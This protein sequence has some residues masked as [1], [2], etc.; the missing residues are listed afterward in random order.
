MSLGDS[1][2]NPLAVMLRQLRVQSG[3]DDK[4]FKAS[5][6]PTVAMKDSLEG[7]CRRE[8]LGRCASK[9]RCCKNPNDCQET[10]PEEMS[11]PIASLHGWTS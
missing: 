10:Y 3:I 2:P 11:P 1:Q 7:S 6:S 4:V 5:F 9:G 8:T